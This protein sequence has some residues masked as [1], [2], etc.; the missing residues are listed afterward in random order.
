VPRIT[1]RGC[2]LELHHDFGLS[3]AV[4][5]DDSDYG[6]QQWHP[7]VIDGAAWNTWRGSRLDVGVLGDDPMGPHSV[8][9]DPTRTKGYHAWVK[10]WP[11]MT[12]P[13]SAVPTPSD[14]AP[15]SSDQAPA[16]N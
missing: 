13:V 11:V 5:R 12:P 14:P 6:H 16:G 9:L 15:P 4:V 3:R 10:R 7:W 8:K 2:L 1:L